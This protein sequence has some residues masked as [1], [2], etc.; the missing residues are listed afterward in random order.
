MGKVKEAHR[1]RNVFTCV[2]NKLYGEWFKVIARVDGIRVHGGYRDTRYGGEMRY[3]PVF[4]SWS[5]L[6]AARAEVEEG[7]SDVGH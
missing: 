3:G 7:S 6:L 2:T 5:E 4:L 1:K